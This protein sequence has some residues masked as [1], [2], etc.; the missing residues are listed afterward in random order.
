[1]RMHVA[2]WIVVTGIC[3]TI[4]SGPSAN[5]TLCQ[6]IG[7]HTLYPH[8]ALPGQVVPV[9]TT[10]AGSC[11]SDGE[12]YFGVRVDVVDSTSNIV[13]S[14]NSTPIGYNANNFSVKVSNAALSP[15]NNQTWSIDVNTYLIE[16]GAASGKYLLN[17]TTIT[18]QIGEDPLPEIQPAPS[19]IVALAAVLLIFTRRIHALQKAR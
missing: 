8:S 7:A 13:L 4:L 17:S 10:V 1:M 11:T 9:T 6:T 18:I 16:A 5:A 14:S 19:L 12:D 3:L 2:C 15:K